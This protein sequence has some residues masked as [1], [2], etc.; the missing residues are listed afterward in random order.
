MS[1]CTVKQQ[2]RDCEGSSG[3]ESHVFET[4]ECSGWRGTSMAFD[5]DCY[6]GMDGW[7]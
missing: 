1:V 3:T 4:G 7:T 6:L 5:V 2:C